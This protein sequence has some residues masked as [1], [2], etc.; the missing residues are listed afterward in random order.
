MVIKIRKPMRTVG[1]LGREKK[2]ED[3]A[4]KGE[5]KEGRTDLGHIL[6]TGRNKNYKTQVVFW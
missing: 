4:Y 6:E 3:F 1:T 2:K 5:K